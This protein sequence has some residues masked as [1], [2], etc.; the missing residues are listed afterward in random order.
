M[1][2]YSEQTE[3]G[4]KALKRAADK[5]FNNARKNNVKIPIWK[6]GK[7]EFEIPTPITEQM[8]GD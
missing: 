3:L 6:N 5:V 4:L 7:V 1:K 2:K 8:G